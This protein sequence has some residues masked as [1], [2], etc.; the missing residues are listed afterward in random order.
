MQEANRKQNGFQN[1]F[2]PNNKRVFLLTI[3][4]FSSQQRYSTTTWS[5]DILTRWE[6]LKTKIIAGLNFSISGITYWSQGSIGGF[7]TEKRYEEA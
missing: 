6:D 4:G 3:K 2:S 5:G 7:S 1:D